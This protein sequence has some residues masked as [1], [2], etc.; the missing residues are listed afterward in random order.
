M[1]ATPAPI[2]VI[3]SGVV[4][5]DLSAVIKPTLRS[6]DMNVYTCNGNI[7]GEGDFVNSGF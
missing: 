6:G 2:T 7:I 1:P 3:E 4:G 5:A